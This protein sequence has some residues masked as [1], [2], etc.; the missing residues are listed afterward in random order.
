MCKAIVQGDR[1]GVIV[2]DKTVAVAVTEHFVDDAGIGVPQVQG[3]LTWPA[4]ALVMVLRI[5][6]TWP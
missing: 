5:V 6:P 4:Q 2:V 3:K 1:Q